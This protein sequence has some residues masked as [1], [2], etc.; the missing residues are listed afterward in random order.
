MKLEPL[1]QKVAQMGLAPWIKDAKEHYQKTGTYRSSD[2]R[3]ILGDP[4]RGVAGCMH[5]SD[6][7]RCFMNSSGVST[8]KS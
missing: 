2:L 7:K 6:A 4:A 3:R 5:P 8:K 1:S